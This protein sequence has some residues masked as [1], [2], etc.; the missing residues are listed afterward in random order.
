M[1]H[2]DGSLLGRRSQADEILVHG[3]QLAAKIVYP[4][5]P[6]GSVELGMVRRRATLANGF[7]ACL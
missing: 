3:R 4:V 7:Q 6:A 5:A 2:A 1:R